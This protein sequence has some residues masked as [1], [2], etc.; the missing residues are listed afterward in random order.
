MYYVCVEPWEV[1]T[2]ENC[3]DGW[4][5]MDNAAT[6]TNTEE[7]I[8]LWDSK[9]LQWRRVQREGGRRTCTTI[10][11]FLLNFLARF[12]SS[13]IPP[14]CDTVQKQALRHEVC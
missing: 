13:S 11:P 1:S 12:L 6:K 4:G 10:L 14:A 5:I 8:R 7:K 9:G 3:M 2:V